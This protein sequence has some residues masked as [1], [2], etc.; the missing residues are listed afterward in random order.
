MNDQPLTVISA[1]TFNLQDASVFWFFS[2]AVTPVCPSYFPRRWIT[3]TRVGIQ[4]HITHFRVS[5]SVRHNVSL[6]GTFK[7]IELVRFLVLMGKMRD[8]RTN[9]AK[10]SSF[11]T[12]LVRS[13]KLLI[14]PHVLKRIGLLLCRRKQPL[15]TD[16]A[17]SMKNSGSPLFTMTAKT[18]NT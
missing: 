6:N 5:C 18:F 14:T 15:S 13:V 7:W 4:P 12:I 1:L 2:G 3:R 10:S 17:T 9:D 16:E 11:T 8:Q